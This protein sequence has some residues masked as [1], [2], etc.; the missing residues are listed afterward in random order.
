VYGSTGSCSALELLFCA[1]T[2]PA[3]SSVA[4]HTLNTLIF[5]VTSTRHSV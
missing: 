4:K 1:N 5:I 3:N 2:T